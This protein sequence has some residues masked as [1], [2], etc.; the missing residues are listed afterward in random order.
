MD[1]PEARQDPP[2]RRT[3]ERAAANTALRAQIAE[4]ERAEEAL[5]RAHEEL[6]MRVRER[7]AELARA[8]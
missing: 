3:A 7:T 5:K 6:E 4:R 2:R 1:A 8:N